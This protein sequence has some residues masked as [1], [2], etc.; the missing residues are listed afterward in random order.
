MTQS[1]FDGV[2]LRGVITALVTLFDAQGRLDVDALRKLV[3]F[4]I[5][6]GVHGLHPCGSTG[7]VGVL[8]LEERQRIAHITVE[9]ARR[10]VPVFVQTGAP[11]TAMTVAL[12]QHARD[13]GAD[14]ATL[15][16]PYYYRYDADGL[17]EHYARVAES[18]PDFPLYLYN[19]PQLTGNNLTP[20][21]VAAIANR[22]PNVLGLKDSSGML[23]PAIDSAALRDGAFQVAVGSDSL[24]LSALV[25]GLGACISGCA[26]ACPEPFVELYEAYWRGDLAAAQLAQ[27]QIQHIRRAM[28]VGNEYSLYKA[29]LAHRGLDLGVVRPPLVNISR[30]VAD[31]AIRELVRHGIVL[32]PIDSL[33][34]AS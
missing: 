6:A 33:K 11:S 30:D 1:T 19:I 16:T 31:N 21:I 29:V 12:T 7:E 9:S 26:N 28:E 25:V 8:T 10:R 32:S 14:G 20:A 15:V 34:F 24:A 3:E 2:R 23:R 18:V 13:I 5:G 17:I 4:Q 27:A 22:C